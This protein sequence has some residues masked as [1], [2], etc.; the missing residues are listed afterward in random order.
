MTPAMKIARDALVG[1]SVAAVGVAYF[2]G[3]REASGVLLATLAFLASMAALAW[4]VRSAVAA[5]AQGDT[6]TFLIVLVLFK[7][8][9]TVLGFLMLARVF[10]V[11]PISFGLLLGVGAICIRGLLLSTDDEVSGYEARPKPGKL[12]S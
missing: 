5:A 7:P 3:M 6:R 11:G 9:L 12:E 1:A 2:Y 4:G 10:G 8:P